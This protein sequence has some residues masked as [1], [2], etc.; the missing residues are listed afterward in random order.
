MNFR[1]E[2]K[3][4]ALKSPFSFGSKFLFVGSCFSE[5]IGH[6]LRGSL[7]PSFIN[8][9]GIA[10]NPISIQRSL[11]RLVSKKL[12]T[13][14]ELLK[15]NEQY[16]S[17]EHHGSFNAKTKEE[18]LSKI[19]GHLSDAHDFLR[20]TDLLVL[21][22]GTSYVY[23]HKESSQIVSNCHRFPAKDFDR[24]LV[25][26]QDYLES[27]K[28]LLEDLKAFNPKLRILLTVSP[29]R[30]LRDDFAENQVSKAQLLTLCHLVGQEFDDCHYFPAYEIMM[31]D[32]RD[33]RFYEEDL[34]HP[35]K[36][37]IEYIWQ[38]F[39]DFAFDK[40]SDRY[41]QEVQKIHKRLSHRI[42]D[43]TDPRSQRYIAD[44][45]TLIAQAEKLY[46][47][48]DWAQIIQE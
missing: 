43:P 20:E 36:L 6:K 24:N 44:T 9:F 29:I 34:V 10:Y 16:L 33:Y 14:E 37:A 40:S 42:Q 17:F 7:I 3:L 18:C 15:N 26:A 32:L 47:E 30:H 2:I 35:N 13:E 27:Y 1:S 38:K 48:A 4:K 46:P 39:K 19:N 31:D 22:F 21:T 8:P 5:N 25:L 45:N 41:F 12:Y 28:E 23:K 11:K